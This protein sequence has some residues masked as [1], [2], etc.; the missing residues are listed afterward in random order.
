LRK[1]TPPRDETAA[2]GRCLDP[3]MSRLVVL[4]LITGCA[5]PTRAPLSQRLAPVVPP[6]PPAHAGRPAPQLVEHAMPELIELPLLV[7]RPTSAPSDDPAM[8]ACLELVAAYNR[9]DSADFRAVV[10]TAIAT[11]GDCRLAADHALGQRAIHGDRH[12]C[13]SSEDETYTAWLVAAAVATTPDRRDAELRNRGQLLWAR[14][15][16]LEDS[17]MQSWIAAATAFEQAA[18]AAPH[19]AHLATLAVDAWDNAMRTIRTS[20]ARRDDVRA[21]AAGL[22]RARDGLAGKRAAQLLARLPR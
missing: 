10:N 14:A 16:N 20:A 5:A 22:E 18:A 11:G 8:R 3:T 7:I 1:L 13:M 17:Q 6:P 15:A 2:L 12:G 21:I 9:G 19:D 4:A